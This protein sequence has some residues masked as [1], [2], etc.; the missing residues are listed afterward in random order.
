SRGY[1]LVINGWE[2]AG[3]SIRNHDTGSQER[4]FKLLGILPEEAEEKFGF[5]LKALRYGAPPHGGIAFG[6]DRLVM[7]LVGAT[8]I[9]D[10]IAFP[11]TTSALSLMDG[12][13]AQVTD[14]QLKELGLSLRGKRK[15][16]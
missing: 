4:I 10:V 3:G 7:V 2:I 5:L 6:F 16:E 9:R 8:Q 13:P 14:R 15:H 12:A 11:K 1:D